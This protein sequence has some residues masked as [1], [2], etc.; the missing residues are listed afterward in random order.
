MTN[1]LLCAFIICICKQSDEIVCV[2]FDASL[3]RPQQLLNILYSVHFYLCERT[4][5]NKNK[6]Y[7]GRLV[8]F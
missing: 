8:F 6:H 3:Q 4:E 7:S 5:K 2:H 1:F